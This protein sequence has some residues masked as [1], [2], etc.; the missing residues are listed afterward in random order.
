MDKL[1]SLQVSGTLSNSP[2]ANG[3]VPGDYP[4]FINVDN[5][6]S[7]PPT[8]QDAS[9]VQAATTSISIQGVFYSCS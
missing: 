7:L 6:Y 5:S 2:N 9:P 1:P 3:A 8:P 4:F